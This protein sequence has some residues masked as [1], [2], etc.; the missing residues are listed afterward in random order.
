[1][2]PKELKK[3]QVEW[4]KKLKKS[5]FVDAENTYGELKSYHSFH[6]NHPTTNWDLPN[7]AE[8]YHRCEHFLN[9]HKFDTEDERRIWTLHSNGDSTR[10]ISRK[11]KMSRIKATEI[12]NKLKAKMKTWIR[13]EQI[14]DDF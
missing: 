8:Y 6:F 3:L 2:D 9:T 12:L 4:Q 1:M 10:E 13:M 7:R 11:L 14:S 5:G